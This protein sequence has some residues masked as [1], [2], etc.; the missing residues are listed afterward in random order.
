MAGLKAC[1]QSYET[2]SCA[3]LFQEKLPDCVTP[4][5]RKAGEPCLYASQCE[6]LTCDTSNG[7]CGQCIVPAGRLEACTT[8]FSCKD[9][10]SCIAGICQF[11][12]ADYRAK[13]GDACNAD[14]DCPGLDCDTASGTCV[15]RPTLGMS[16]QSHVHCAGD[17]YCDATTF[18]CL[19]FPADGAACGKDAATGVT[20]LCGA[21][22]NC[23]PAA[24]G[25]L[26]QCQKAPE[27]GQPC[28]MDP[29]SQIGYGCAAGT[30]CDQMTCRAL[31]PAGTACDPNLGTQC[32]AGL[33][34]SCPDG[35]AWCQAYECAE[36]HFKGGTCGVTGAVCN[37]AFQCVNGT[38]LPLE[39]AGIFK[40]TCSMQ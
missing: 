35:S 13:I 17:S 18:K 28:V 29:N 20:N 36:L 39:L 34:C 7:S 14:L 10:L 37:P 38:C 26:Y 11:N 2:F 9:G 15:A 33:F 12:A 23:V 27:A 31:L 25:P 5:T 21:G 22:T 6:S 4:G 16:C 24:S 3:D 32:A 19:A 30:F 1:A 40:S 8:P